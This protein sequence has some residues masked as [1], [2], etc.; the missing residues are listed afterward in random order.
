MRTETKSW[1][2]HKFLVTS[3]VFAFCEKDEDFAV[4][5]L[6]KEGFTMPRI[7]VHLA[8]S[9]T[10]KIHA[11]GYVGHTKE[12]KVSGGEICGLLPFGFSMNLSSAGAAD[13]HSRSVG[14]LGGNFDVSN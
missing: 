7:P 5:R 11:L 12:F 1:N 13:G 8:I 10:L 9:L 6:P 2:S 4:L 3:G 14:Y